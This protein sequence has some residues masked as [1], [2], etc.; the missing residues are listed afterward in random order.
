MKKNITISWILLGILT[1]LAAFVFIWPILWAISTSLKSE[2]EF[3][4]IP[5]WTYSTRDNVRAF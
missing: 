4:D 3:L 1:L 2:M 5:N